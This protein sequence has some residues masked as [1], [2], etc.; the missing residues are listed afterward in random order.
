MG[1]LDSLTKVADRL[2]GTF[3]KVVTLRTYTESYDPATGANTLT[4]V[5]TSVKALVEEYPARDTK[6]GETSGDGIV[7]GDRKVTI[8]ADALTAAPT[9]EAKVVIGSV[10]YAI[11][12]IDT[13]Y[14]TEDAALYIL[15]CRR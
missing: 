14:A 8:A 10:E 11:V 9:T 1:A 3:G 5:D 13:Q 2:V 7:R 6:G 15:Q 4:A 12:K